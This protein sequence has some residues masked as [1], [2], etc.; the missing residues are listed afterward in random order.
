MGAYASFEEDIKG[1]IEVGKA[2]DFVIL[3][4][5]LFNVDINNIKNI[6]ILNTYLNGK[7]MYSQL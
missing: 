7:C 2:A 6:K 3:E 1:S 4:E 5:N